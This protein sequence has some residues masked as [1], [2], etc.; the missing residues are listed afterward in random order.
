MPNEGIAPGVINLGPRQKS[1][2]RPCRFTVKETQKG[3]WTD[4]WEGSRADPDSLLPPQ[5][6]LGTPNT[7]IQLY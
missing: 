5:L 6:E 1:A 7:Y 4:G 3:I 2:K